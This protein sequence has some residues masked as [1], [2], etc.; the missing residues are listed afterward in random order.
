MKNGELPTI[1]DLLKKS[2]NWPCNCGNLYNKE[3]KIICEDCSKYR[4]L[5]IYTNIIFNPM[6]ITKKRKKNK[7][8][9]KS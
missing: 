8:E 6:K 4:A 2:I 1:K 7:Y 5:E 9:K 3:G